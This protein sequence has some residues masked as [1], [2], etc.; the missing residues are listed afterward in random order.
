V[1]LATPRTKDPLTA[2]FGLAS[3]F[4]RQIRL[5]AVDARGIEIRD[6]AE[7]TVVHRIGPR[8]TDHHRSRARPG[9]ARLK[10][11]GIMQIDVEVTVPIE[12]RDAIFGL[13][14]KRRVD[15]AIRRRE[16]S[17]QRRPV[18][19]IPVAIDVEITKPA[20]AGNTRGRFSRR[21]IPRQPQVTNDPGNREAGRHAQTIRGVLLQPARRERSEMEAQGAHGDSPE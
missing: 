8:R 15:P 12:H 4:I 18:V 17:R 6:V 14:R 16:T 5:I 9:I 20:P 11:P 21:R 19:Q 1:A 7:S 3:E 2:L 13:D 10:T